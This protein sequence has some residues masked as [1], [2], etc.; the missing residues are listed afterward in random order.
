MNAQTNDAW[1]R[2]WTIA[3][4]WNPWLVLWASKYAALPIVAVNY[5]VSEGCVSVLTP[6]E[7]P[8]ST[9]LRCSWYRTRVM[10]SPRI[11]SKIEDLFKEAQYEI[12]RIRILAL[13]Y[14]LSAIAFSG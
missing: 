13:L 3:V 5:E 6:A 7:L 14:M 11:Q 8:V 9:S 2:L 10:H 4:G 12:G 1:G